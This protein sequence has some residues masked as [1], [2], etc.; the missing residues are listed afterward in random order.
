MNFDS[1]LDHHPRFDLVTTIAIMYIHTKIMII[2]KSEIEYPNLRSS[3]PIC[4]FIEPGI[5]RK[6][7]DI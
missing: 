4:S 3:D 5:L 1:R 2:Q 6:F 7:K